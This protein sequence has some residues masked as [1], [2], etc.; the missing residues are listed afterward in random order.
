MTDGPEASRCLTRSH[1]ATGVWVRPW[2]WRLWHLVRSWMSRK[3]AC[4][5]A[6]D[7]WPRKKAVVCACMYIYVREQMRVFWSN[8]RQ[9]T[10]CKN[11]SCFSLFTHLKWHRLWQ[12]FP[13]AIYLP[14]LSWCLLD[15]LLLFFFLCWITLRLVHW[16]GAGMAFTLYVK[17]AADWRC[18]AS[19]WTSTQVRRPPKHQ[20]SFDIES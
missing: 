2:L 18:L 13:Q 15:S 8:E 5:Y 11:K 3:G 14:T 7:S 16:G 4:S 19:G 20:H 6:L 10:S 9:Y 12:F 17:M 1:E